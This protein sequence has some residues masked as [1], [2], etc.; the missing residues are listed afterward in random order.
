M[1]KNV[2]KKKCL[3]VLLFIDSVNNSALRK[4]PDGL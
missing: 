2:I 3:S 4:V 1:R